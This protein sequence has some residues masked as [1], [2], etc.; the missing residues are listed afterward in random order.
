MADQREKTIVSRRVIAVSRARVWEAH[1]NA[2]A[3]AAWWGPKGFT[4][5]FEVFE[6]R[7]GGAW[8]FV[9]RGPDGLEFRVERVF[10]EIVEPRRIVMRNISEAHGFGMT[11]LAADAEGGTEIVWRVE[12]DDR[13]E[14]ERVRAAFER[15]NEENLDRLE[16]W[17]GATA[18]ARAM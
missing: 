6:F 3:L 12:F 14:C 8:R 17:L 13:E 15:A 9:M 1:Q 7:A 16:A 2:A 10:L 18:S 5:R 11:I 4:N